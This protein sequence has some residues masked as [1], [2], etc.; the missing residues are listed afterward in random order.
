MP[1]HAQEGGFIVKSKSP[2]S[3]PRAVSVAGT[4]KEQEAFDTGRKKKA[5]RAE[6]ELSEKLEAELLPKWLQKLENQIT[7]PHTVRTFEGT[8]RKSINHALFKRWAT[9]S[10][11][12]TS[13]LSDA[14]YLRI[15]GGARHYPFSR[16]H[17]RRITDRPIL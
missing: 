12:M 15:A 10:G 14:E 4:L 16:R 17:Y 8:E 7:N 11:A 2:D 5:S 13:R 3:L 1:D 9:R 6:K